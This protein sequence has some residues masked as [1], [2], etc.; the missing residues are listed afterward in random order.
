MRFEYFLVVITGSNAK[1]LS[2]ELAT[3]LTGRN[4]EIALYPFSFAE[5]CKIKEVDLDRKTTK[6]EALRR[7]AFDDYLRQGGFPELMAIEDGRAYVSGLVDNILKRD[8]EQRYKISYKAAFEQMAHHLLNV[9]PAIVVIKDLA[10]L[11]HFKSE[12]TAKNYVN[13]LKEAYMLIGVKKYSQKS[14]VRAVQEKVYAVDVAMMSERENAFA[15]DNLGHGLETIV[16]VHLMRYC[17]ANELDVY[18]L[19]ERNSECDFVVCKKNKVLQAIQVSYDISAQKTRK[20]EVNGLLMAAKV[21]K[22]ENLLLL[23]DHESEVIEQGGH[24]MKVQPVYEWCGE[25]EV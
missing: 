1:L 12:H 17:K 14:K 21:T 23:T 5:F 9:S 18:Y 4:K 22:C 19:N 25:I 13:Y 7:G 3:H 24:R 15:G 10:T 11:F 6:A 8:I 16:L 20:R 2:G